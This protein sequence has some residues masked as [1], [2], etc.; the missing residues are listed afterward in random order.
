[1]ENPD[2]RARAYLKLEEVQQQADLVQQTE[3]MEATIKQGQTTNDSVEDRP[4]TASSAYQSVPTHLDRPADLDRLNR[5][6][7]AEV[8]AVSMRQAFRQMN[9]HSQASKGKNR[10]D[11][12]PEGDAYMVHLHGQWGAGKSSVLNFLRESLTEPDTLENPA[13]LVVTFNARRHQHLGPPW[14]ALINTLF[15]QGQVQ[16]Q[17]LDKKG[18]PKTASA[19][20]ALALSHPPRPAGID[21]RPGTVGL[22]SG[23]GSARIGPRRRH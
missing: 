14:W 21:Q 19:R 13:W 15:H 1:M 9:Q 17:Q 20:L 22:V 23:A 2:A 18:R 16:L 12:E 10:L 6:P 3:D 7:F 8:I 4:E 11:A 5:R